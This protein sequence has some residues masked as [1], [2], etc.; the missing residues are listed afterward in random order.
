MKA[1]GSIVTESPTRVSAAAINTVIIRGALSCLD[2]PIPPP[3]LAALSTA[4]RPIDR[5]SGREQQQLDQPDHAARL[6]HRDERTS[7]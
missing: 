3:P 7:G 2:T 5:A 4:R 6:H 1:I